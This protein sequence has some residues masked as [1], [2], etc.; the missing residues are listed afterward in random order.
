MTATMAQKHPA[1]ASEKLRLE[2]TALPTELFRLGAVTI[3]WHPVAW[4]PSVGVAR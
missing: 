1:S 3:G 2:P 4:A